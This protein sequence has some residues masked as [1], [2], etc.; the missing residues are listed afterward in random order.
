MIS[1]DNLEVLILP[2]FWY[3][4]YSGLKEKFPTQKTPDSLPQP[5]CAATRLHHS[6]GKAGKESTRKEFGGTRS[7][8]Q[9]DGSIPFNSHVSCI[10]FAGREQTIRQSHV[11][12]LSGIA[13][14]MT[15]TRRAAELSF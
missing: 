8:Q 11:S 12:D 6:P 14:S 1:V 2:A 13:P 4:A 5:F 10:G 7:N 9:Y 3:S 15:L